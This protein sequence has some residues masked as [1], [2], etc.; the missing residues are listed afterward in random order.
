MRFQYLQGD[1]TRSIMYCSQLRRN[2]CSLQSD[3]TNDIIFWY[4]NQ[5][6][7]MI[8]FSYIEIHS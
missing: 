8:S 1:I 2:Y 7:R 5:F 3:C 6:A 4:R